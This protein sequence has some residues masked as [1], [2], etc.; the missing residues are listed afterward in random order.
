MGYDV[1][2]SKISGVEFSHFQ[3][4]ERI[5]LWTASDNRICSAVKLM[6]PSSLMSKKMNLSVS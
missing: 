1:Q 3:A 5:E 2:S 4:T 6:Y